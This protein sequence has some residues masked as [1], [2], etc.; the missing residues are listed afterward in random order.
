[1]IKKLLV[2]ALA[3]AVTIGMQSPMRAVDAYTFASIDV[4]SSSRTVATA[5]DNLGRIVGYY[6]DAAGTHGFLLS[7]GAFST[8]DA[9]GAKWT[10]AFGLNSAGQLSLIHI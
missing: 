10:G 8:I 2:A 4:P 7:G 6:E 3:A 9:P 5:I 1:M